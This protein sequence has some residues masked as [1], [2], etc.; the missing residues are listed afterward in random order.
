MENQTPYLVAEYHHSMFRKLPNASPSLGQPFF[1]LNNNIHYLGV[2]LH[3]KKLAREDVQPLVDKMLKRIAGC[4]GN[5]LS[6]AA[7]LV[8]IKACLVSL[9]TFFP[10]LSFPNGL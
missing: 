1:R 3:F 2:P 8:L 5:L 10:L 4:R 6:Y 9:R 7:K